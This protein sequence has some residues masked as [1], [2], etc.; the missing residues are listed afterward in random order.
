MEAAWLARA[1]W[2]RR[3]AWMWPTFVG[4][5]VIDAV[6]LTQ[7]PI[8]GTSQS[9]FGGVLSG[10]IVSLLA[11]VVGARPF[12]RLLRRRRPDL[13]AL[14]ARDYAGTAAIVV[15]SLLM[16]ALGIARHSQLVSHE[17]ALHDAVDRAVAYFGR[18]APSAFRAQIDHT[19][20]YVIQTG[21]IYRVCVPDRAGARFYCVVVRSRSHSVV[22]AGSEP[23]ATLMLG[24]D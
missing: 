1:R 18:H 9:F 6:I 2:R 11:V 4:V 23:N 8:I 21:A 17:R 13:P 15:A 24:T 22:P 14:I 7:R 12:G 5:V 20:T 3:G 16:V 19:D 10:L